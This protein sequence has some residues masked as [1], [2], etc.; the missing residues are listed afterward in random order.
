VF[1]Q[2]F[3]MQNIHGGISQCRP[4]TA[5]NHALEHYSREVFIRKTRALTLPAR[6]RKCTLSQMGSHE[7]EGL[8][9]KRVLQSISRRGF[10]AAILSGLNGA[11]AAAAG[12]DFTIAIIP[13]RSTWQNIAPTVPAPITPP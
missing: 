6:I 12:A 5:S 9:P 2:V 10:G 13:D 4:R 3:A 1:A 11:R 7:T 8:T